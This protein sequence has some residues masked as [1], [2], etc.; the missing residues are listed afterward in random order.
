MKF[1][2]SSAHVDKENILKRKTDH[3]RINLESDVQ[4]DTASLFDRL[5]FEYQALPEMDLLQV[6][7]AQ[8]LFSKP[9][10]Q[11]F[12]ISSMTGGTN[13]A[14]EIN[15]KLASAAQT[16]GFALGVGSQRAALEFADQAYTFQVRNAA[17][18]ILLFANL[19][20]IQLNYG[21]TAEHCQKAVDMIE[22]DALILHLNPLQEALQPEGNT[23]FAGLLTKIE[24]VCKAMP[25]PVIIKEVGWGI[26]GRTAQRLIEAGVSAIDVSGA[27]GTS[28]A[29]VEMH[30]ARTAEEAEIASVFSDWGIPTV[31]CLR[32]IRDIGKGIPV[33]ASGGIRSGV[34]AAKAIALG[35]RLAG[36]AG[37]FLRSANEGEPALDAFCRKIIKELQVAM[38]A[39]GVSSL[40]DLHKTPLYQW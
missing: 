16:H 28:W 32:Q 18:D 14:W 9:L 33:F 2:N 4:S 15:Q 3:L 35:A 26:S 40:D 13:E 10:K 29:K 17:P 7:T 38:F 21:Y 30:R 19:G 25:V 1:D 11:P 12:L 24:K 36:M 39:A 5:H 20:A 22:A 31:E 27:G 34:D 37:A 6:D 23:R 8:V